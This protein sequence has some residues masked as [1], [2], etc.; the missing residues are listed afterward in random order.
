MKNENLQRAGTRRP[1]FNAKTQRRKGARLFATRT[2]Q[3]KYPPFGDR[4][5]PATCFPAKQFALGV[6]APLRLCVDFRQHD[7]SLSRFEI[8]EA[9]PNATRRYSRLQI[10]ATS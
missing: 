1:L 10:C 2:G 6:F 4:I 7:Y 8:P 3:Q 5:L 9:L